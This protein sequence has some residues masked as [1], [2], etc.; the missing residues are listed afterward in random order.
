[1]EN[2]ELKIENDNKPALAGFFILFNTVDRER[3]MLV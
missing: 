3:F 1:M 2:G